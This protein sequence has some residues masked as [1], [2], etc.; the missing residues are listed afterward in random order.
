MDGIRRYALINGENQIVRMNLVTGDSHILI[1][2]QRMEGET[3]LTEYVWAS[4]K[5]DR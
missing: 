4:I 3:E 2:I 1:E 5:E